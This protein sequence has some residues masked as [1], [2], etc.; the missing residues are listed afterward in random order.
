MTIPAIP[1]MPNAVARG[2]RWRF[3]LQAGA[4]F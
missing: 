2:R 3:R 1:A 4:P